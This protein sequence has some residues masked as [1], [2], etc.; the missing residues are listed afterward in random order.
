MSRLTFTALL[1]VWLVCFCCPASSAPVPP[2]P[3]LSEQVLVGEWDYAFAGLEGGRIV[4]AADGAYTARHMVGG[5]QYVGR[6]WVDG[7]S[8]VL[9]EH[10][11]RD[12]GWIEGPIRYEFTMDAVTFRGRTPT[13][14]KVVLSNPVR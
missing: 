2:P 7:V 11:V 6:W 8:V 14:T 5:T 4:F 13:G 10:R 12:D 1:G 9:I 3:R